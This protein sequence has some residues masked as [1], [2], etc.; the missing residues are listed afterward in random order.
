MRLG[1]SCGFVAL[2][3]GLPMEKE[4][5]VLQMQHRELQKS[6][7]KLAQHKKSS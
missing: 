7:D 2:Y 4:L 6:Y 3:V 1:R 5:G